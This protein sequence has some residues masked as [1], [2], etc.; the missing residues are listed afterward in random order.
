MAAASDCERA[1]AESFI[2]KSA[3]WLKHY[4]RHERAPKHA[5]RLYCRIADGRSI[6]V[7]IPSWWERLLNRVVLTSI[8]PKACSCSMYRPSR[9]S[10]P[11]GKIYNK[12]HPGRCRL[13]LVSMRTIYRSLRGMLNKPAA[14]SEAAISENERKRT[15]G[16]SFD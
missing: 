9:E 14:S 10:D 13:L 8:H 6:S 4:R 16:S 7:A 1:I 12:A 5:E 3:W 15:N 11:S 2:R